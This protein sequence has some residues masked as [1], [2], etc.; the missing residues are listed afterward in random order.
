[1]ATAKNFG[2][3]HKAD[4]KRINLFTLSNE[5]YLD[6]VLENTDW[7]VVTV[8]FAV[9]NFLKISYKEVIAFDYPVQLFKRVENDLY[10][11]SFH[12]VDDNTKVVTIHLFS[13]DLELLEDF[14]IN[15]KEKDLKDYPEYFLK[16]TPFKKRKFIDTKLTTE[17]QYNICYFATTTGYPTP[18]KEKPYRNKFFYLIEEKQIDATYN[19]DYDERRDADLQEDLLSQ[20]L[21]AW[22]SLSKS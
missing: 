7:N 1:M 19:L 18:I 12:E 13:I 8:E 9:E 4:R 10:F 11:V 5:F 6:L 20:Q 2:N 14:W 15:Q 16:L 17:D 3:A 21:I 22:D